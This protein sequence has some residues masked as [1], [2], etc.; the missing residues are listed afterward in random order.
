VAGEPVDALLPGLIALRD[1]MVFEADGMTSMGAMLTAEQAA[2][3]ARALF[4]VQ[5]E[6]LQRDARVWDELAR[7]RTAEN[8]AADA[9]VL[10]VQRVGRAVGGPGTA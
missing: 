7:T 10:L 4:R 8:R 1:S 6:L 2:P 3:L 5:A 9:L